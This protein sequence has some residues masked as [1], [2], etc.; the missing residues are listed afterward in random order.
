[1]SLFDS[2]ALAFPDNSLDNSLLILEQGALQQQMLQDSQC[3]ENRGSH[4]SPINDSYKRGV[5]FIET[6]G[7]KYRF[8]NV[9]FKIDN[10][11]ILLIL[12]NG[13]EKGFACFNEYRF[14]PGASKMLA[15]RRDGLL[16]GKLNS[17]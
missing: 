6:S 13:E 11:V 1:M 15:A 2:L 8:E 10:G 4:L 16:F 17:S 14:I 5:V 9:Q 12:E 3:V 7:K